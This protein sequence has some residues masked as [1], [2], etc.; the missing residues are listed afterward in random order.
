MEE[1]IKVDARNPRILKVKAII[2]GDS[3]L[4][5]IEMECWTDQSGKKEIGKAE[6]KLSLFTNDMI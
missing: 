5:K 2:D 4:G 6:V 3:H 1:E